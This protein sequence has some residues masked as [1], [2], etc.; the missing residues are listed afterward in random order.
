MA[1]APALAS[2]ETDQE[3][4]DLL[5]RK[6]TIT[7]EEYDELNETTKG[8]VD[9]STKGGHLKFKS[10][11]DEFEF[12]VGGRVMVDTAF[13]SGNSDLNNGSE[14]RRARLF[15]SGKV[16]NDWKFKAQFGFSGN[17]TDIEDAYLRYTGFDAGDITVGHFKEPWSLEELTSSKYTTF[18]ERAM[19]VEAFAPSRKLGIGFGHYEKNW[20]A[21]VG[22]FANGESA[23]NDDHN[24][25]HG[26]AARATYAPILEE[27]K[28]IHLGAYGEYRDPQD[29]EVRYRTRPEAHIA[30][31]RLVDTGTIDDVDNTTKWGLEAASV[32]GPF[33]LQGEYMSVDNDISGGGDDPEFDGWYAYGSWFI[34]GE[35]RA[36]KKGVF[37]RVKPKSVVGKG[38]HG[39]WEL[40]A[41]YSDIDLNDSGVEGGE[42]KNMTIGVNWYATPT[43][44]LMANY[45][46]VL[47]LNESPNTSDSD[48]PDIYELRAQ[49]DF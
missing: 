47:D 23:E 32:W 21:N 1:T 14:I 31:E 2:P 41:R 44:R 11:D 34:T 30:N 38:G 28:V 3:L 25:G 22:V 40:G 26:Y 10:Q 35:S 17:E 12:Q 19:P 18:M 36:Y 49:I 29:G 33:S 46:N 9:V 16:F 4:L 24:E 42:E 37:S 15:M 7:Q 48:K 13:F 27:N 45:V 6:G 43:I 5:L 39:A 8:D 20:T